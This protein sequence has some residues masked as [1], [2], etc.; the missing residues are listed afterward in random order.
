MPN[1]V[2][3]KL[4]F[5][6]D[7]AQEIFE[8]IC[9]IG[10]LDFEKLIPI[11][12]GVYNGDLSRDDEQDFPI[13]WHSWNVENWGTKWNC[14]GQSCGIDDNG[15][16]FIQFDT[17]WSIPYPIIAEFCNRFNIPFEHRYFD[18]GWNFWG[19]ETWGYD[20]HDVD[21]KHVKRVSKRYNQPEDRVALCVELKG[22][23]PDK[24]DDE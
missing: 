24:E 16:A 2:T 6:S 23:D 3:H 13:N 20:K 8:S 17:A 10:K 14:Y 5:Q 22:Y 12:P 19:I 15:N 1:H 18:E 4:I 7:K 11:H 21:H 9:P